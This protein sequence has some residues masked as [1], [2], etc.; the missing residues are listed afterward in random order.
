MLLASEDQI[1]EENILWLSSL[2]LADIP[3]NGDYHKV[4]ESVYAKNALSKDML[5]LKTVAT[6]VHKTGLFWILSGFCFDHSVHR[7][8]FWL[9][10]F[11]YWDKHDNDG[12]CVEKKKLNAV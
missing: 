2:N 9:K 6:F 5:I 1:L 3:F 12:M 7:C 8:H 11:N 10:T 4:L